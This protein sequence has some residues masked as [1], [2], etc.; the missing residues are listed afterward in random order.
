MQSASKETKQTT[1]KQDKRRRR[2]YPQL[3]NNDGFKK[4][5]FTISTVKVHKNCSYTSQPEVLKHSLFT[6][7]KI[8]LDAEAELY[9]TLSYHRDEYATEFNTFCGRWPILPTG[10][11]LDP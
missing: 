3:I 7:Y 6:K 2:A 11:L 10:I 1:A 5:L 4:A 8:P 9:L